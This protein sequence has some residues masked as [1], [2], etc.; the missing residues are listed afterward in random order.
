MAVARS[1]KGVSRRS[2]ALAELAETRTHEEPKPPRHSWPKGD[3]AGP[4]FRAF[5]EC[6]T[7]TTAS[8]AIGL[9]REAVRKRAIRDELFREE[10]EG[11]KWERNARLEQTMWNRAI[12]G[13]LRP[14][15]TKDG[16]TL[17]HRTWDTSL[18][19]FIVLTQM[20]E[21]WGP[22]SSQE[23]DRERAA[24]AAAMLHEMRDSVPEW[25]EAECESA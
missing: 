1:K 11:A 18:Q 17:Y 23:D 2:T 3:W 22:V 6:H 7:I 5:R 9:S 19:K 10:L 14:V 21:A 25:I 16:Q 12:D 13:D 24:K 15:M 4:F 20:R 8:K